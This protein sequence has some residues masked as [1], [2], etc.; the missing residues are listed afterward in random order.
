MKRTYS[1]NISGI[2]FNIE[3]DCYDKLKKYLSSIY[4]YFSTFEDSQEI[5]E[6]IN[7]RIAEIFYE[8]IDK[9]K[10]AITA[11]D[12]EDLIATMGSIEDFQESENDPAYQMT[13]EEKS[14]LEIPTEDDYRGG[15]RAVAVKTIEKPLAIPQEEKKK[16]KIWEEELIYAAA[17]ATPNLDSFRPEFRTES[18]IPQVRRLF[19]DTKRKVLGGVA[20]GLGHYLNIDPIWVRLAFLAVLSGLWF[21]P[22][23][24]QVAILTY[25]VMWFIVPKNDH[26]EENPRLRKLY[27]HPDRAVLGGV[28]SGLAV[29]LGVNEMAVR[30]FFILSMLFFGT[31]IFMYLVL[32]MIIPIA[33][34]LTEKMQMEGQS[35][36]LRNIIASIKDEDDDE[37]KMSS[38]HKALVFPFQL[39]SLFFKQMSLMLRPM[40]GFT[41]E[42]IRIVGGLLLLV[43]SMTM[44]AALSVLLLAFMGLPIGD[45]LIQLGSRNIPFDLIKNS[46][47]IGTPLLLSASISA[48]VPLLFMGLFGV[49]MLR[50]Q[51]IWNNGFGWSIAGLW[52][53]SLITTGVGAA[54]I[55][56][57]F[58]N[59]A[60]YQEFENFSIKNKIL[61]LDVNQPKNAQ[62]RLAKLQLVGYD[63]KD[64]KL[65]KN[66]LGAG[67]NED[68]AT[69]NAQMITY[70]VKQ[71]DSTLVFDRGVNFKRNGMYR[72]QRLNMVLHI[73]YGQIFAMTSAMERV[74]HN[75][76]YPNGYTIHDLKTTNR[77][78]FTPAGLVCITCEPKHNEDSDHSEDNET[79]NLDFEDFE[80]LELNGFFQLKIKQGDKY[81]VEL[82]R[83]NDANFVQIEQEGNQ[84]QISQ[85]RGKRY[86]QGIELII[87]MPNL[88]SL[89]LQGASQVEVQN[90][91]LDELKLELSGASKITLNGSANVI[92][93]EIAGASHILAYGM[94]AKKVVLDVAG[95]SDVKVNAQEELIVNAAGASNI[96]YKGSPKVR[97]DVMGLSSVKRAD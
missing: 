80:H 76:I 41:A 8:K 14:G 26:L 74:L 40:V 94:P 85:K 93:A 19:R 58:R 96:R 44:L 81:K 38:A 54:S 13:F 46:L 50:R 84:L 45:D 53:I 62:Y 78:Q 37:P 77:W 72:N 83:D 49:M 4:Q 63:G 65:E 36:N 16:E 11:Q 29:Y 57:Q 3:E 20:A 33:K 75:T 28:C 88:Q 34:T 64:L 1:I 48:F 70:Q 61:R 32:W 51:I 5:I 2:I 6:D 12:V 17:S 35:V 30:I 10:P 47:N 59:V 55:A 71:Q 21:I 39:T 92:E 68:Q 23:A 43:I 60:E 24:P 25:I 89:D 7:G 31:G 52:F 73:P 86:S 15:S 22:A 91:K 42:A 27:R 56:Q 69:L 87:T 95:A 9:H 66:F 90:F 82:P 97:K 67:N 79:A 18:D